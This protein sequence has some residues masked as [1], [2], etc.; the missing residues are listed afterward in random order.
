LSSRSYS[1]FLDDIVSACRSIIRFV[2]GMTMD[3][4]FSD[5]KT[6]FAV[7]H[8]YEI[9]GE[10]V[11]HLPDDLKSDHPEIPWARMTAVRNYIAHGYFSVDDVILFETIRQELQPLLPQLE[12][13]LHK[14]NQEGED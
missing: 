14:H 3:D 4:Y 13:I 1:D 11:K 8:A 12:A 9:M 6:R 5:E 2:D 7:M 10:A